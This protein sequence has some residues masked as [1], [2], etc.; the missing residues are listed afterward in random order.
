MSPQNIYA[1]WDP[2]KKLHAWP[3][4][5]QL[6]GSSIKVEQKKQSWFYSR[7]YI[8]LLTIF[9]KDRVLLSCNISPSFQNL[10]YVET[11]E[12]KVFIEKK[13]LPTKPTL[14]TMA[15][16]EVK[17]AAKHYTR[18][19]NFLL[20]RA[21]LSVL[22]KNAAWREVSHIFRSVSLEKYSTFRG[23]F[24]PFCSTCST[25]RSVACHILYFKLLNSGEF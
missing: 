9:R 19:L 21:F 5:T 4:N 2:K 10:I 18:L 1:K 20:N 7:E 12:T 8:F 11:H 6:P 23:E 22:R 15:S 25:N 24:W 14:A 3:W 16:G 13:L 17:M